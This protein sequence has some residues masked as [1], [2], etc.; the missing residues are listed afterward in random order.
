[1]FKTVCP[2]IKLIKGVQNGLSAP[3]LWKTLIKSP[4]ADYG[5]S[6]SQ[7]LRFCCQLLISLNFNCQ[8]NHG[9]RAILPWL[10][11]KEERDICHCPES[12]VTYLG[13]SLPRGA[14]KKLLLKYM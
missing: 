9:G 11:R 5:L 10:P 8:S 7:A 4:E 1:M 2:P 6:R 13:D 14:R 3:L 12:P